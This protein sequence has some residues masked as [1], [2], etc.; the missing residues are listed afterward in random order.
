MAVQCTGSIAPGPGRIRDFRHRLL[1]DAVQALGAT[2]G[3]VVG[4]TPTIMIGGGVRERR[5]GFCVRTVAVGW[6]GGIL[7]VHSDLARIMREGAVEG[8]TQEPPC[9][10]NVMYTTF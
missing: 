3:D 4:E 5:A 1:G 9:G 10:T 6:R 7:P 8:E 2:F